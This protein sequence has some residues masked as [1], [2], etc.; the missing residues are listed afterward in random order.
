MAKG[1]DI[2][3]RVDIAQNLRALIDQPMIR[4]VIRNIL[5]NALK[6]T[7]RG[8]EI[9]IRA[10]QTEQH[11]TMAIQ[12]NG[13]GMDERVLSSVFALGEAKRRLGT[14]GES[15]TGLGLMLCKQFIERHGG[16][17]WI[18]SSLGQGTT[19]CFTIAAAPDQA[20]AIM[21]VDSWPARPPTGR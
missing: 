19:V 13:I 11:V 2:A 10:Q 17:I 18:E 1:K 21:A 3:V 4:T 15:G 12:D 9:V 14:E 16:L 6:F 7:P 20:A 5:L 8:G